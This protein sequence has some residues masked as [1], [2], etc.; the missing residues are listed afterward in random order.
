MQVTLIPNFT[1][2]EE[3]DLLCAAHYAVA[4]MKQLADESVDN[5][6]YWMQRAETFEKIASKLNDEVRNYYYNK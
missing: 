6:S 1:Y 2:D 5:K 4:Y 3:S